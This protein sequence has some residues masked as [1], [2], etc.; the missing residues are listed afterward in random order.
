MDKIMWL[1][2]KWN[3]LMECLFKIY[4]KTLLKKGT[5]KGK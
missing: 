3:N 5:I 1:E 2:K 4:S